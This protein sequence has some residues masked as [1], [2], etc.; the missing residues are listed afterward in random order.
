M[1]QLLKT[2]HCKRETGIARVALYYR[3]T[4]NC[5]QTV[6][7]TSLE[8][9]YI[10]MKSCRFTSQLFLYILSFFFILYI[11]FSICYNQ[12]F[13]V[14]QWSHSEF[15]PPGCPFD[16]TTPANNYL[17]Y[18]PTAVSKQNFVTCSVILDRRST[19]SSHLTFYYR[20]TFVRL[21]AFQ[22]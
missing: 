9:S 12:N 18:L 5:F 21:F 16:K 11:L 17:T 4:S 6:L 8:H 15:L 22:M 10:A 13:S 14:K 3:L 20:N 1:Q 7:Q 2:L 19:I